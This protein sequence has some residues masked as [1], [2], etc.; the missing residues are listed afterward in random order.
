MI[1]TIF[2]W[3]DTDERLYMSHTKPISIG[4]DLA[5]I[6]GECEPKGPLRQLIFDMI[7]KTPDAPYVELSLQIEVFNGH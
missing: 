5:C 1:L 2:A 7:E 3:K 4:E 6:H